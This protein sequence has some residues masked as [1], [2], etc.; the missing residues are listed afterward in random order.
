M[1]Y[2]TVRASAE[3]SQLLRSYVEPTEEKREHELKI[4][5]AAHRAI[6]DRIAGG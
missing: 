4:P 2:E 1:D 6:A 5:T 3:R